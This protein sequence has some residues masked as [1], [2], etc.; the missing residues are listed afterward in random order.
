MK[1]IRLT[2]LSAIL[3]LGM[4][5]CA[6]QSDIRII[7]DR[8]IALERR[9]LE[10]EQQTS[11][12]IDA[13]AAALRNQSASLS[14]AT[15]QVRN[16]IQDLNGKIEEVGFQVSSQTQSSELLTRRVERIEQMLQLPAIGDGRGS[17][18]PGAQSSPG[19]PP[20][21]VPMPGGLQP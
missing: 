18:V 21:P 16:D 1:R 13:K 19:A 10:L 3:G 7:E 8:V 5:G 4:I 9:N 17:Y 11:E 15:D 14:A 2:C 6:S 20:A 12:S